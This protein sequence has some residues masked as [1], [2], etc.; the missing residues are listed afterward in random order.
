VQRCSW[1]WLKPR[2]Q[3]LTA[4][5]KP[6]RKLAHA[7]IRIGVAWFGVLWCGAVWFGLVWFG[8][9]AALNYYGHWPRHFHFARVFPEL[10]S[11]FS[12]YA[13]NAPE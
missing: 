9:W 11:W 5:R 1:P 8:C 10:L 6:H 3:R 2:L 7:S 13:N 12:F 4:T